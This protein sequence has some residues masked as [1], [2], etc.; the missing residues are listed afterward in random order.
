MDLVGIFGVYL[1][2]GGGVLGG[3]GSFF[4]VHPG[5]FGR[6]EVTGGFSGVTFLA[7]FFARS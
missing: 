6:F 5:A 2:F 1:V 7:Q 4:G 3:D